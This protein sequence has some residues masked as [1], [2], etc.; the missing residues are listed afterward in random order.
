MYRAT[1]A[2]RPLLI[3]RDGCF[4]CGTHPDICDAHRC[5]PDDRVGRHFTGNLVNS[6]K[7]LTARAALRSAKLQ[8]LF[9][10]DSSPL[11]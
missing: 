2:Q 6:C 7:C 10:P 11:R 4:A 8:P 3:A 1:E 5:G 9:T